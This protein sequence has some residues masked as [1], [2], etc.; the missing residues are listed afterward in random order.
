MG[1]IDTQVAGLVVLDLH[2]GGKL[3]RALTVTKVYQLTRT[4]ML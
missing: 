2:A 4:L 3:R 1:I